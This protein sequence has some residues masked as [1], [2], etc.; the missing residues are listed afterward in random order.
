MR[1]PRHRWRHRAGALVVPFS[2][3]CLSDV[4]AHS[5]GW[6]D[7]PVRRG[8]GGGDEAWTEDTLHGQLLI[9]EWAPLL[10][11]NILFLFSVLYV[12][13]LFLLS[14]A[15]TFPGHFKDFSFNWINPQW[16]KSGTQQVNRVN[17]QPGMRLN[18]CR[19][20]ARRTCE[21]S[22][23]LFLCHNTSF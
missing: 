9:C 17:S 15:F 19:A 8:W 21:I 16:V 4:G 1:Q 12:F 11:M 18:F 2:G 3:G 5:S 7:G 14:S 10:F 23:R 13:V 6:Q 20:T 22:L